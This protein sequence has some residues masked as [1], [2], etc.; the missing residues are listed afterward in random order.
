MIFEIEK[1]GDTPKKLLEAQGK[2]ST[3]YIFADEFNKVAGSYF[4]VFT[5][6][7]GIL[8]FVSQTG[9][10]FY[11]FLRTDSYYENDITIRAGIYENI[12][13]D[14][15]N[16]NKSTTYY[17]EPIGTL[18]NYMN[19]AIAYNL[20]AAYPNACNCSEV[21]MGYL[22]STAL[23]CFPEL[24]AIIPFSYRLDGSYEAMV[25]SGRSAN[26]LEQFGMFFYLLYAAYSYRVLGS[27]YVDLAMGNSTTD[28]SAANEFIIRELNELKLMFN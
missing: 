23:H 2:S 26:R 10:A 22:L 24:P 9:T 14:I 28:R 18:F 6:E 8:R 20:D 11:K 17:S 15:L 12:L 13:V 16:K 25:R 5:D 21:V 1:K 27:D 4:G 7:L 19:D 3:N